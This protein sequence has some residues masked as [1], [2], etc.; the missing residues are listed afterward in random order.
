MVTAT[1]TI[2]KGGLAEYEDDDLYERAR[3]RSVVAP[4]GGDD[5]TRSTVDLLTAWVGR[6]ENYCGRD[7]LEILGRHLYTIAFGGSTD[8]PQPA[9][10]HDAFRET[11]DRFV[12]R[13]KPKERLR[14]RLVIEDDDEKVNTYP[15]E[16]VFAPFGGGSFAAGEST[17]LILTRFVPK[18][19]GGWKPRTSGCGS[20]LFGRSPRA[21]S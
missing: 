5:L 6:P 13:R 3:G 10:I 12:E 9:T 16:F 17:E 14:L 2:K 18:Y 7:E 20:S 11:Y 21:P 4:L 15:W 1:L 19:R 8:R